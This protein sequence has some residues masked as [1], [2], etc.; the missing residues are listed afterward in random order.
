[1]IGMYKTV[2]PA[3]VETEVG[4][5]L[6]WYEVQEKTMET[7][8]LFHAKYECIHPFQDGNGRSG[9]MIL[10][11]E[12]LKYPSTRPF[13]ILDE[14]R[15][16]YLEGLKQFREEGGCDILAGLLEME[17]DKYYEQCCYF[18]GSEDQ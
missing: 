16:T 5:L 4:K 10:F 13:V 8:A 9:R 1:M 2:L 7:L 18:M 3:E 17:A 14:D 11:R 12:S 15:S 6:E